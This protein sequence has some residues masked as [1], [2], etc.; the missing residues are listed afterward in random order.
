MPLSCSQSR[1][2]A[3]EI[4][5]SDLSVCN[6]FDELQAQDSG[7]FVMVHPCRQHLKQQPLVQSSRSLIMGSTVPTIA[8]TQ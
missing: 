2:S 5:G 7:N 1:G 8:D 3:A 4:Y 6:S